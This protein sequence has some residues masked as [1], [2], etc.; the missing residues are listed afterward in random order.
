[1]KYD[2]CIW[3]AYKR[4]NKEKK[5]KAKVRN[6]KGNPS[7]SM[8]KKK[9]EGKEGA[10]L[11]HGQVGKYKKSERVLYQTTTEG[12]M[13][14]RRALLCVKARAG[15]ERGDKRKGSPLYH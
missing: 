9:N 8:A 14:K 4:I 2:M 11:K 12:G 10:V 5:K 15:S 7:V 3:V 6:G 13:R 1:L